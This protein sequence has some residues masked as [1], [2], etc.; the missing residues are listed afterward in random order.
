VSAT[1]AEAALACLACAFGV[2]GCQLRD[3]EARPWHLEVTADGTPLS[4]LVDGLTFV[5][6][7]GVAQLVDGSTLLVPGAT[8][9]D[10]GAS[11]PLGDVRV[12]FDASSWPG[13]ELPQGLAGTEVTVTVA[14]DPEGIGPAREPLPYPALVVADSTAGLLRNEFYLYE[15]SYRAVNGYNAEVIYG[16]ADFVAEIQA[17]WQLFEPAECGLVYY[18]SLVVY[19]DA[20]VTELRRHE[21]RSVT[22]SRGTETEPP[23]R[24]AFAHVASWHRDGACQ[25][26]SQAWTQLVA[27]RLAP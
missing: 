17:R 8:R 10:E 9:I 12:S 4:Q 1:S 13:P 18:D 16:P 22:T 7:T 11:A 6:F 3:V 20:S 21:R 14:V 5:Q 2:A 27:W 24:W 26:Q 25:D 23:V 19:G 15:A